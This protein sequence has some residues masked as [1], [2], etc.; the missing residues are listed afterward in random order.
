MELRV[1]GGTKGG[2]AV[3]IDGLE[4]YCQELV[5][6]VRLM[7]KLFFQNSARRSRNTVSVP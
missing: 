5:I 4:S 2:W 3:F 7:R 6:I 1:V